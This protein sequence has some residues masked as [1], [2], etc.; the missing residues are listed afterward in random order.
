MISETSVRYGVGDRRQGRSRRSRSYQRRSARERLTRGRLH[1]PRRVGRCRK[2]PVPPDQDV[3]GAVARGELAPVYCLHGAER[4]LVDRAL[5]AVRAAGLG[6]GVAGLN[7]H[8]FELKES[9]IAVAVTAAQTLP[10]FAKR[11][12]VVGRGVDQLKSEELEPLLPYLA[13]P[14]PATCLVLTADK[15]DGR[16]KPFQVMRKAGYLHEFPR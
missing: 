9:G 7:H 4:F 10:M 11:R 1:G 16:L 12:L 8:V 13:D 15:I 5:A 3:L 14:N 6:G 2:P